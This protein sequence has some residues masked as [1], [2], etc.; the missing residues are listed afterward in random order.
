MSKL[1]FVC[2]LLILVLLAGGA[3]AVAWRCGLLGKRYTATALLQLAPSLP[4]VLPNPTAD[5]A[6]QFANEFEIFRDTQKSLLKSHF[7]IMAALRDPKLK[8][9]ACIAREDAKHNAVAWLSDEI[10]VNCPS[11]NAGIIQVSAAEPDREDA[12]AIVNAVVGAYMNEVVNYDR[13]QRRDRL[14]ELQQVSAEKEEELREK[15]DQLKSICEGTGASMSLAESVLKRQ[16]ATDKC[17]VLQRALLTLRSEYQR[18]VADLKMQE[19]G[20]TA[21][22]PLAISPKVNR[23]NSANKLTGPGSLILSDTNVFT[24]QH[25]T[26]NGSVRTLSDGNGNAASTTAAI[27]G[28]RRTR[29]SLT[30]IGTGTTPLAGTNSHSTGRTASLNRP[31]TVG[32][33]QVATK[34][35]SNGT[36]VN[37]GLPRDGTDGDSKQLDA[38]ARQPSRT[39]GRTRTR[40]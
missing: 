30:K 34:S 32:T 5:R 27:Q 24:G 29:G 8:N 7:V 2:W 36:T 19:M 9:R 14:S 4:T 25:A 38:R 15:K 12:A 35:H 39:S 37:G 20:G 40:V 33:L 22:P 21:A 16:L 28:R 26:G 3:A 10:H 6:R 31:V 1:K 18:A 23:D 13:Q 17:L 11:A